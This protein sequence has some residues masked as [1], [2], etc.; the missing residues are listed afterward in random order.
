MCI[1][2][3]SV[4]H[5]PLI[6]KSDTSKSDAAVSKADLAISY[7]SFV[8][9][10]IIDVDADDDEEEEDGNDKDGKVK[11]GNVINA[12]NTSINK[13][14]TIFQQPQLM[15]TTKPR[16]VVIAPKLPNGQ[17]AINKHLSK[18]VFIPINLSNVKTIKVR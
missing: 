15:K 12:V 5:M 17:I 4:D 11:N 10:E 6:P 16:T 1:G 8:E 18:P 3:S 9:E 13:T 7:D 2:L 14:L